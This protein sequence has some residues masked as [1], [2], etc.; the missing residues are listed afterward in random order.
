MQPYT[1]NVTVEW[2]Y[3]TISEYGSW[4][5]D[6]KGNI[7]LNGTFLG[8]ESFFLMCREEGVVTRI[9]Q[10]V[11]RI[12]TGAEEPKLAWGTFSVSE[13]NAPDTLGTIISGVAA[14]DIGE[15]K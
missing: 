10:V 1:P 7:T 4:E 9:Q 14:A 2:L 6:E 13:R 12:K 15:E 8:A 3:K 5:R 11:E